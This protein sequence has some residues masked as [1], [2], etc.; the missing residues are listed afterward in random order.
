[1]EIPEAKKLPNS[2]EGLHRPIGRHQDTE[3]TGGGV[4]DELAFTL[5][6][7][8]KGI[9]KLRRVPILNIILLIIIFRFFSVVS[10]SKKKL[11]L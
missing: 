7:Q 2:G 11:I 4:D 10:I 5:L 8:W 6:T 3:W 9:C 1:M